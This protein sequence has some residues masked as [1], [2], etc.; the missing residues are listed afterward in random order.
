MSWFWEVLLGVLYYVMVF[1]YYLL[2]KV[3]KIWFKLIIFLYEKK[4]KVL[5]R[6]YLM[7]YL[8]LVGFIFYVSRWNLILCGIMGFFNGYFIVDLFIFNLCNRKIK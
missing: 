5:L 2:M 4:V 8:I 6:Y 1:L 7:S 3:F